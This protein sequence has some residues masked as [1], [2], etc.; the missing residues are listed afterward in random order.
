VATRRS[1][2][3]SNR[4]SCRAAA[5]GNSSSSAVRSSGDISFRMADDLLVRHRAQQLLLRLDVEIFKNVRRQRVR[6]DPEDD[7]LLVFR[8]IENDF[9]DIGRRPFA[10]TS[11]SAAKL[12]ARSGS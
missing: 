6:Q 9:G 11:R 12:R 2:G 10:K 4:I 5:L 3:V 7:D 1:S 8:Q